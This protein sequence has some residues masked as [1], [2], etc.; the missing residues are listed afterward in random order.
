MFYD[1]AQW[2]YTPDLIN[3][4]ADLRREFDRFPKCLMINNHQHHIDTQGIWKFVPFMSR[5]RKWY[6]YLWAFPTV[7][8][9]MKQL[10]IYDNCVFSIMGP[11]S[12]IPAHSGHPGDHLR[13]HLGIHTDGAAWIRVGTQTQHWAESQVIVFDDRLDHETANPSNRSRVVFLF[14][15]LSQDFVR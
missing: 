13:V 5:G 4:C 10:P 12:Q 2:R 6:P 1:P 3:A 7:K 8:R 11:N 9:L 15:I 14:D